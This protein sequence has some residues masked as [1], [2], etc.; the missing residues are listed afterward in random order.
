VFFSL[1]FATLDGMV[2]RGQAEFWGRSLPPLNMKSWSHVKKH[3][4]SQDFIILIAEKYRCYETSSVLKLQ[5]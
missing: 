3:R 5:A 4:F 1:R 2:M